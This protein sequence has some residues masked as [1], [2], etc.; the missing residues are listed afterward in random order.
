MGIRS[1]R[2]RNGHQG[3]SPTSGRKSPMSA[4]RRERDLRAAAMSSTIGVKQRIRRRLTMAIIWAGPS[5]CWWDGRVLE[6][7]L[8]GLDVVASGTSP[9]PSTKQA[10]FE[11]W[12]QD[13][14]RCASRARSSTGSRIP[15]PR[16]CSTSPGRRHDPDPASSPICYGE[17]R[18]V[19]HRTMVNASKATLS[20]VMTCLGRRSAP[21]QRSPGMG[22]S[23]RGTRSECSSSIEAPPKLGLVPNESS[24]GRSVDMQARQF[25]L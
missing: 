24:S 1:S 25:Q 5:T 19:S 9:I 4:A 13:G 2:L 15:W 23:D 11:F 17:L 10:A 12:G 7:R 3:S 18:A 6:P 8:S 14:S 22:R 16:P 20:R 21:N